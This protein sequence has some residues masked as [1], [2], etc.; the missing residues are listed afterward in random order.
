MKLHY[1][2]FDL[3]REGA[4]V[5]DPLRHHA[6]RICGSGV[7]KFE[8]MTAGIWNHRLH[9]Q[10]P[11][12]CQGISELFLNHVC[13]FNKAAAKTSVGLGEG[14]CASDIFGIKMPREMQNGQN[15]IKLSQP[16]ERGM[17]V[18]TEAEMRRAHF[19]K[20][21]K[22]ERFRW[23]SLRASWLRQKSLHDSRICSPSRASEP[24][25]ERNG[26]RTALLA[27]GVFVEIC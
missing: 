1:C 9:I 3:E 7:A 18:L 8:R 16:V 26:G 24:G 13:P 25:L 17:A 5:R 20:R 21:A 11:L 15:P 27:A 6:Q 10:S 22:W 4:L 19:P 23:E 12:S 2:A 14:E